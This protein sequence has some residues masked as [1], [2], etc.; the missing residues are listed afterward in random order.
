MDATRE[1]KSYTRDDIYNLPDKQR[2]ELTKY[3]LHSCV[4]AVIISL[5]KWSWVRW[6]SLGKRGADCG[7]QCREMGRNKV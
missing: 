1:L 6:L 3:L 5:T 2:A 4:I 7:R